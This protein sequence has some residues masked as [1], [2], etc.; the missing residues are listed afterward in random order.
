MKKSLG[1][2]YIV[3]SL[4]GAER[5]CQVGDGSPKLHLHLGKH[6]VVFYFT[7]KRNNVGFQGIHL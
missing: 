5:F 6:S 1:Q 3:F 4:V 7:W 2:N